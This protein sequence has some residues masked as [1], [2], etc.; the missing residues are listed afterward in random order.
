MYTLKTMNPA[1]MK[2]RDDKYSSDEEKIIRDIQ[3]L[4]TKNRH[5]MTISEISRNLG[6]NVL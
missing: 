2:I 3:Q 6:I 1:L 5:G 4:L